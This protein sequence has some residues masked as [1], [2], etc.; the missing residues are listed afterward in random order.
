MTRARA[1][2]A[3]RFLAGM[4]L[5][6]YGTLV[7]VRVLAHEAPFVGLILLLGGAALAWSGRPATLDATSTLPPQG[8][9]DAKRVR[10]KA[11]AIATLSLGA[12]AAVGVTA[13]NLV[14]AS[15]FT[16]PELAI[17]AYGVVLIVAAP[18]MDRRVG[19]TNGRTLVAWSL[20]LLAAPLG[21]YA[22]DAAL[23]AGVGS[24][25][26]DAF[27]RH[28]LVAPMAGV[29]M[30]LGFDVDHTGQTIML[31][32]AGARLAL[33]VGVVCAGLQPGIL[34][35]GVLGLHA[36]RQETPRARLA[37]YLGLGL[38]GVYVAN[39]V[40]LIVLALV[41]H[42]W[43][44]AALQLAHAHFGWILFVAW[45]LLFWG[46]ILRRLE[47]PAADPIMARGTGLP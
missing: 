37:L 18:L 15:T 40:R 10:S 20:P 12:A 19:P 46:F 33:T 38:L 1:F 5:A 2:K 4:L 9:G 14:T 34:F 29:L 17:F 3:S 27:I 26:L 24:S 11:A 35:L 43:G 47:G 30:A 32:T 7:L 22:L 23:D 28:A 39:L 16:I 31:G 13:Y 21:M 45:M 36:L 42:R 6:G 25:P 41:G 44:G 8:D